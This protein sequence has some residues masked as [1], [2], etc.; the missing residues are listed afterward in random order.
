MLNKKNLPLYI[1]LAVPV[2]M[3]IL[4]AAFI[5]LPGIGKKPKYNFLYMTGSNVFI[6]GYENGGYQVSGGHLIYNPPAADY[7]YPSESQIGDVHFYLYDVANNQAKEVTLAEAEGYSLDSSNTSSD[8][9][10]IQQGNGGSGD[11]LFGGGGGDYNSWFIKGHNRAVKLNLKLTGSPYS[12]FR[13][14]GWTE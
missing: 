1:A 3:I 10:T 7:N 12:N 11:F 14:L 9:Y 6:Y 2:L 8:G 13:F 5:Y 4:V